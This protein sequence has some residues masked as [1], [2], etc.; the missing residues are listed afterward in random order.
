M[1]AFFYPLKKLIRQLSEPVAP[2]GKLVGVPSLPRYLLTRPDRLQALKDTLLSDLHRPVVV[3]GVAA[4]VG[5]HGM[6]GIGKSVLANLLA[7]DT[8]VRRGFPGGILWVPL[9]TEPNLLEVQRN[10]ARVFADPCYFENVAQGRAKLSELLASKAVLLVI[11][12]VWKRAHAEAFNVLGP[13]CRAVITTRDAGLVTSLCGTEYKV[14]LLTEGESL[15]LL[16]GAADVK[17]D[18]LP[19]EAKEI[20]TRCGRLPLAMALCSGMVKRG[21]SWAGI[22]NRLKQTA[23]ESIGNRHGVNAQHS[24]LWTAMKISVDALTPVEQHRFIELSVFPN[25]EP[26]PEAAVRTLWSHTGGLDELDCEDLL[27]NLSDRSLIRLDTEAPQAGQAPRRRVSLHDLLHDFATNIAENPMPLHNQLLD[28]YHKLCPSGWPSGPN[29]GYFF[30][31]IARHVREAR[32]FRLLFT[33]ARDPAFLSAQANSVPDAPD[34]PLVL[35]RSALEIACEADDTAAMA[36]FV[37]MHAARI[38]SLRQQ[39]P[40]KEAQRGNIAG[41]VTLATRMNPDRGVL[42][43]LNLVHEF[44]DTDSRAATDALTALFRVP[45][46]RLETWQAA[47]AVRWLPSIA[48]LNNAAVVQISERL[49]ADRD[50]ARLVPLLTQTTRPWLALRVAHTILDESCLAQA[51]MAL[52]PMSS[53]EPAFDSIGLLTEALTYARGLRDHALRAKTIGTLAQALASW[54]W[55]EASGL[56]WEALDAT[57]QDDAGQ[58]YRANALAT[59]AN[60]LNTTDLTQSDPILAELLAQ[61]EALNL[62]SCRVIALAAVA[63][64]MALQ[65][66]SAANNIARE[67]WAIAERNPTSFGVWEPFRSGIRAVATS[68]LPDK[69]TLLTAALN[70]AKHVRD[71]LERAFALSA[72]AEGVA[73][74]AP[75]QSVSFLRQI[76]AS[77]RNIRGHIARST[78]LEALAKAFG[79]CDQHTTYGDLEEVRSLS[80]TIDG[81]EHRSRVLFALVDTSARRGGREVASLLAEALDIARTRPAFRHQALTG[82]AEVMSAHSHS[83]ASTVFREVLELPTDVE[84]QSYYAEALSAAAQALGTVPADTEVESLNEV[85]DRARQ[86]Q[87][88]PDRVKPLASTAKALALRNLPAATAVFRE[89]LLVTNEIAVVNAAISECPAA[90]SAVANTL[91]S[92]KMPEQD[93]LFCELLAAVKAIVGRWNRAHSLAAVAHVLPKITLSDL[94]GASREIWKTMRRSDGVMGYSTA[95][96]TVAQAFHGVGLPEAGHVFREALA[97]A[98]K[99]PAGDSARELA[100]VAEAFRVSRHPEADKLFDEALVLARNIGRSVIRAEALASVAKLMTRGGIPSADEIFLES[101]SSAQN[102]E[103]KYTLNREDMCAFVAEELGHSRSALATEVL[104]EVMRSAQGIQC[105]SK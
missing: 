66:L 18:K 6:G 102:V 44:K 47:L 56:L 64:T 70:V 39:S 35:L 61:S 41:A 12:D 48:G 54:N 101:L 33:L 3:T 42:W 95:L 75:M 65:G 93:A 29:D 100:G 87:R 25:D 63:E 85:L 20:V 19:P 83:D 53:P 5:V 60:A 2:M 46:P 1:N 94:P 36:E 50:R 11:D 74:V 7:R 81:Y 69:A 78:V 15:H 99:L 13:R 43:L 14:V 17:P 73:C 57:R 88:A 62:D 76:V 9:G 67:V 52:N 24:S 77:A 72:V 79:N 71:E 92:F 26:V 55:P 51:L 82:V 90:F 98:R 22:L 45:Q 31:R 58:L 40:F 97:L 84:D 21:V 49:L 37:L 27:I 86:I 8:E 4:R 16:T 23:L 10:V 103:D 89:A 105:H 34:L 104:Y 91:A 32:R 59:L 28:A 30:Q 80:R 68:S 38:E 96:A